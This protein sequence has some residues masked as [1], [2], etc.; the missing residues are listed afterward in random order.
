MSEVVSLGLARSKDNNAL[1]TPVELLR[2]ALSEVE[3]G[4]EAATSVMV[5]RLNRGEENDLFDTGW[6]ASNL[7]SSEMVALIEAVKI[8]L[9]RDMGYT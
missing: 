9:L 5:I 6:W 2:I 3:N 8:G 4:D 7:S 1:I